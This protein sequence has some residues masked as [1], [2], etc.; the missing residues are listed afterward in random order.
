MLAL[1][2]LLVLALPA[3]ARTI[4][5]AAIVVNFEGDTPAPNAVEYAESTLFGTG[6][7]AFGFS[8]RH[9]FQ[10][11]TYGQVDFAGDADD[12]YGPYTTAAW[13]GFCNYS[14]WFKEAED[15]AKPDGFVNSNYDAIVIYLDPSYPSADPC[16]YGVNGGSVSW[17]K[18][19][20]PYVTF[21]ELT[22]GLG[23]GPGQTGSPHAS[24]YRCSEGGAPVAFSA[25]CEHVERADP[26]DLMG[27][28]MR[29]SSPLD[30]SAWRKLEFG[31]IPPGDAPIVSY[32]GTY[33]IAPVEQASGTRMLRVATAGGKFIDLDFR[34][35]LGFYDGNLSPTEP[36]TNGVT[37][38]VDPPHFN[39]E[40]SHLL[41]TTPA[42]E[43]WEDS[44]LTVGRS[45]RDPTTGV[46]IETL[47]AGPGGATVRIS[48][49]PN[50]PVPPG[51]AG[52]CKVP[53]LKRKLKGPLTSKKGRIEAKKIVKVAGCKLGKV[54]RARSQKKRTG[55]VLSQ[56]PKPGKAAPAGTK[57]R[58]VVSAGP[59]PGPR[60]GQ[61]ALN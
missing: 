9:Y 60:K 7:K 10:T 18:G 4:R 47:S 37:L 58:V 8:A 11:I 16:A 48:G 17:M 1:C 53:N 21:H 43:S 24:G 42:T 2:A 13:P 40:D 22:H 61:A 20:S 3:Q 31:V 36:V 14:Q 33:T 49:L 35:P 52:G 56:Q 57:V 41:D 29:G 5:T 46:T 23:P 26:F 15:A 38:R 30:V 28:G 27:F 54:K 12:V 25:S 6:P 32:S 59:G 39:N 19:I 50:P 45:F 34:Q 51:G 44:P 55:E